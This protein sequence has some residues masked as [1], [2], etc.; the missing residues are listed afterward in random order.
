MLEER[1]RKR[2]GR[3][4][5]PRTNIGFIMEAVRRKQRKAEQRVRF[6]ALSKYEYDST[7]FFE[8]QKVKL[9]P[10]FSIRQIRRTFGERNAERRLQFGRPAIIHT[11][12]LVGFSD[13]E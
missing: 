8:K 2:K 12:N 13:Y 5:G 7:V 10:G 1:R 4:N 9:G 11:G 6:I 3:K